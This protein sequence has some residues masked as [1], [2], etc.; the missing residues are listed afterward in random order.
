MQSI[1]AAR[2]GQPFEDLAEF[3]ARIDP[4]ALNRMQIENLARAG[5]FDSLDGNRNRVFSAADTI[6]R[7][8]QARTAEAE[9]G[10]IGLFGGG[11]RPEPLRVAAT[12]DWAPLDRLAFEA[13]AIGFHLTA[14]PMD[15]YATVL[16]RLHVVPSKN[17]EIQ[18]QAGAS[19]VKLAG[20]IVAKKDRITRTGSR[21]SWLRVSDAF[22]SYEVTV[23]SEVLGR[24]RDA[25]T[26]GA[27]ILVT[28]DLKRDGDSVR[29]TA[30]DIVP[31]DQAVTSAGSGMRVWLHTPD[32]VK[33]LHDILRREGNGKGRVYLLPKLDGMRDVEI[34]L[35]GGFNVT[36]RLAQALKVVQGI[37]RVEEV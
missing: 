12:P 21:M 25:I 15:A 16:K 20:T 14:H 31:L 27:T 8:A 30:Q 34:A 6:L 1:E 33:A 3:S 17:I 10:Q 29:I 9:S 24:A 32:A 2:D 11:N 13:E 35:P 36:P 26:D 18:A 22:G 19:R 4:K 28:A 5:A 7:R 23:F 37:D